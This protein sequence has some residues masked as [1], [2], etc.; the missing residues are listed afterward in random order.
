MT[1]NVLQVFTYKSVETMFEFG[2]TQSWGA[3]P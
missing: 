1:D 3:R 2:G